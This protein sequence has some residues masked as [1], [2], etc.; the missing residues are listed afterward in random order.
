[1]T[2]RNGKGEGTSYPDS[3]KYLVEDI[4]KI[5]N[6]KEEEDTITKND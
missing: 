4:K 6:N 2:G 3:D 1:M 5:I